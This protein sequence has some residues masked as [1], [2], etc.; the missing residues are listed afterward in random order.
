MTR[1]VLS[2]LLLL[3]QPIPVREAEPP[4]ILFLFADDHRPDAVGAFG[5]PY[6]ETP[7]IDS[8]LRIL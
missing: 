6:I 8:L 5:N 7:S 2:A 1:S 3:A 4:N